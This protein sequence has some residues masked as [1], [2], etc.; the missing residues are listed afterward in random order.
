MIMENLAIYKIDDIRERIKA[1]Y[2]ILFIFRL[3]W[4]TQILLI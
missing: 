4:R 3:V 2:I 1:K